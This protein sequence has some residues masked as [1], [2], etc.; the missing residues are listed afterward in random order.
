MEPA[1]D[2]RGAGGQIGEGRAAV[3]A[4]SG[5]THVLRRALEAQAL[6]EG[7]RTLV[8][9]QD[10]RRDAGSGQTLER[11]S[12]ECIRGFRGEVPPTI[13]GIQ[14]LPRFDRASRGGHIA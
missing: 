9:L 8:A 13:R 11:E 5:E 6:G 3:E 4:L 1:G 12:D 14:D 2:A 7:D 10:R